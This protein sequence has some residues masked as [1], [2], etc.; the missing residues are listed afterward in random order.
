VNVRPEVIQ[1]QS[2]KEVTRQDVTPPRDGRGIRTQYRYRHS[3]QDAK[4]SQRAMPAT[5]MTSSITM[6]LPMLAACFAALAVPT[7]IQ[8]APIYEPFR[9]RLASK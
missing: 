3:V 6:L 8:N 9:Q 7:L 4:A 1:R 5:E 2:Q